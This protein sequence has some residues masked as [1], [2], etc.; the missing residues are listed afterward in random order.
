MNLNTAHNFDGRIMTLRTFLRSQGPPHHKSVS[1][2]HYSRKRIRF[3]YKKLATPKR[4]YTLWWINEAGRDYGYDVPKT[5]WDG[6]DVTI[7][8]FSD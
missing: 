6:Y 4:T 2:Q 8:T 3:E 1:T 5:V 7:K